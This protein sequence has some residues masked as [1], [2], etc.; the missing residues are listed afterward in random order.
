M[1]TPLRPPEAAGGFA[2]TGAAAGACG[3][4]TG[5]TTGCT[6]GCAGTV[7]A[8]LS[9]G[10]TDSDCACAWSEPGGASV[11]GGC[12]APGLGT[13]L[14]SII[15]ILLES[16]SDDSIGPGSGGI[17]SCTWA[18]GACGSGFSGEADWAV[19]KGA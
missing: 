16:T 6:W 17:G 7:W 14:V 13:G 19:G 18:E 10:T 5:M 4:A 3:L 15:S 2:R 8:L 11:E 9:A 1:M 12:W